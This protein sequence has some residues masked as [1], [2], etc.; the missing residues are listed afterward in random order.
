MRRIPRDL[1]E[2]HSG[3]LACSHRDVSCFDACAARHPEIV[4]VYGQHFWIADEVERTDLLR[5]LANERG[6][7]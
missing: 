2:G 5:S 4:D 1:R 7:R 6:A 3:D